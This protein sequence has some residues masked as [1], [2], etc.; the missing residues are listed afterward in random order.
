MRKYL[1]LFLITVLIT[2]CGGNN[3]GNL[4]GSRDHS[5]WYKAKPIGMTLIP[6]GS[7]IMGKTDEDIAKLQN[8][9]PKTVSL[10]SFYMDETE[11]TNNE[12]RQFV[13]WVRD[14]IARNLFARKVEELNIDIY[15]ED[16]DSE[17]SY[18]A[19]RDTLGDNAFQK[20]M[21]ENYYSVDPNY[22]RPLDWT[23]DIEWNPS[24]S[25]DLD[26]IEALDSLYLPPTESPDGSMSL[27]ITKLIYRYK[28]LDI[29]AAVLSKSTER[30]PYI[31]EELISVYPDTTVWIKDFL[32]SYNEPM[33]NEYFWHPAF[34]E[35]P[36]VGV[37][38]DQATAFCNWRTSYKNNYLKELGKDGIS[39][40][41][42]PTE[43]EWE[44]AARGGL[45][46]GIY[47][48]GG[49]YLFNE[50]GCFLANFKPLRGDYAVDRALYTVEVKSY[51]PNDYNLFNM[52]GNV[53]EWTG[54]SYNEA[55][56]EYVS[57]INPDINYASEKRKVV[58]G[59]SW[60]D[61]AYFLRVS[62]RDYEYKDSARSYIGF[63][64]VQDYLGAKTIIIR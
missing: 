9:T 28:W 23:E 35:Y 55:T 8:A 31:K 53:A 7:F 16:L 5:D 17:L 46:S 48:W 20:Y 12:Y 14:S 15:A 56:Y 3:Q 32:Y 44:Y 19:Y 18:Y 50:K 36:V 33:H 1:L 45:P 40:F 64:T 24:Y 49:P 13:Y 10:R 52:A 59:G 27:D 2:S 54:S 11:I 57:S 41:R 61:V 60:K 51:I 63:R 29:K 21:L 43:A 4:T 39:K 62:T 38:W 26:Y 30:S 58:R 34:D 25:E 47:P 42:L 37:T 22:Q 6:G